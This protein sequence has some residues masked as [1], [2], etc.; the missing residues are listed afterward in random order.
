MQT[1]NVLFSS[2]LHSKFRQ[3]LN[4]YK[5]LNYTKDRI[6][7]SYQPRYGGDD[8]IFNAGTIYPQPS[9]YSPSIISTDN[10]GNSVSISFIL[11]IL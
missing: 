5:K 11:G 7:Q 4:I 10:P 8:I 6:P 1:L 9:F 2:F 3:G